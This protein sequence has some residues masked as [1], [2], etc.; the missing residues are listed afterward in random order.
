MEEYTAPQALV[1]NGAKRRDIVPLQD[2]WFS[3]IDN[4]IILKKVHS[5]TW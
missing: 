4:Y 3:S 5:K 2:P 1:N